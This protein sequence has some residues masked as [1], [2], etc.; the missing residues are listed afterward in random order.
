[1][2]RK[3]SAK[4][5]EALLPK[6]RKTILF[7]KELNDLKVGEQFLIEDSDWTMKTTPTAYYYG[8]FRKGVAEADRK[9]AY[10]KANGGIILTRLKEGSIL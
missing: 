2:A 3:I 5:A 1:M 10:Q 8:K 9:M 7:G 4:E 6:R